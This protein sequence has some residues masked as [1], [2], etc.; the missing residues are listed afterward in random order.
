M[1]G[2]PEYL[3]FLRYVRHLRR[4]RR[5]FVRLDEVRQLFS[6]AFIGFRSVYFQEVRRT[7]KRDVAHAPRSV[8]GCGLSRP[9]RRAPRRVIRRA[10]WSA[11]SARDLVQRAQP[12][13][14]KNFIRDEEPDLPV[15]EFY[16][17]GP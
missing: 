4:L 10:P 11:M 15:V 7:L 6:V 3:R 17:D 14:V 12:V 8:F 1:A 9:V 13:L 2:D 5:R 16:I